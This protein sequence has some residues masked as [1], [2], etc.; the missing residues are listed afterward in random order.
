MATSIY[1]GMPPPKIKEWIEKNYKPEV[2]MTKVPLHF[3]AEEPNATMKFI[4]GIGTYDTSLTGEEGSWTPYESNTPITL[5]N[6][7]DKVYFRAGSDEGNITCWDGAENICSTFIINN[8]K[9]AANGNIQSLLDRKMERMDV[10]FGCYSALFSGCT[11]LTK[12]PILPA[13]TLSG[14]DYF[15]MFQGCTSLTQAPALPATTLA[16]RCYYDMFYGC[17]SIQEPK[18]NMPNLTFDEV[19]TELQHHSIFSAESK[20]FEVQCSDKILVAAYDKDNYE[21]IIS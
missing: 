9:I 1:L 21:W 8:G 16:S 15:G 2:D 12:A 18:Y 13:T 4:I 19:K 20:P 3:T 11:S 17:T 14:E 7:G 6:V 5:T 10:S